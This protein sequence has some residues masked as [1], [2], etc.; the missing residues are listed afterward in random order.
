MY[1]IATDDDLCESLSAAIESLKDARD[2]LAVMDQEE[3]DA[4]AS[5]DYYDRVDNAYDQ[6]RD[7]RLTG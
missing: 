6:W 3:A 2:R 7:D 5:Y 1:E 4:R